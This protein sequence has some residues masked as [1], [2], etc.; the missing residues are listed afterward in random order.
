MKIGLVSIPIPGHFNP[1]SALARQLQSRNHD[2][3]MFS[4]PVGESFA[5]AA[6]RP[7]IPFAEREFPAEKVGQIVGP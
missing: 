1:M 5:R 3:V 7:F 2:A 4:P 6:G